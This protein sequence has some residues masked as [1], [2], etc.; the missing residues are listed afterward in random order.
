MIHV[1]V[2]N[3]HVLN[4]QGLQPWIFGCGSALKMDSGGREGEVWNHVL[5]LFDYNQYL[6]TYYYLKYYASEGRQISILHV[7]DGKMEIVKITLLRKTRT[8]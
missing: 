6:Q 5:F 8:W 2:V 1:S 7:N 3:H 4:V